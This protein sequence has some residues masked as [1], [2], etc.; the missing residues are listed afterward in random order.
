MAAS[1][2]DSASVKL[3]PASEMSAQAAGAESGGELDHDEQKSGKERPLQ[4][5]PGLM[6]VAVH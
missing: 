3:W 4:D 2:S 1:T 6:L 5:L